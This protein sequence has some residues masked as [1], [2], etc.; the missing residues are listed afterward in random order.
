LALKATG[1][2]VAMDDFGTGYSSLSTLQ[3]FPFDKIKVDKSFIQ[4]VGSSAHAA[5]I[6]KATLLLG[7]SLNIPV[8]A[9]GVETESHLDFLRHEGCSSVQGYLFGKPMPVADVERL[10]DRAFTSEPVAASSAAA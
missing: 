4:A 2:T 5:A 7:R 3:A 9:E 6:V 8:L 1:V 10:I